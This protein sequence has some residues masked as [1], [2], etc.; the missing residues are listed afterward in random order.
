MVKKCRYQYVNVFL[1]AMITHMI[2]LYDVTTIGSHCICAKGLKIRNVSFVLKYVVLYE[3]Q[4]FC[5]ID[6]HFFPVGNDLVIHEGTSN[7]PFAVVKQN[8]CDF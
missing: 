3:Y 6:T 8:P 4:V 1:C 5:T 2:I 7:F